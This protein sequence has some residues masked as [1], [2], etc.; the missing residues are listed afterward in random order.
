MRLLYTGESLAEWQVE[1]LACVNVVP[2]QHFEH[3]KNYP[4]HLRHRLTTGLT[5]QKGNFYAGFTN[6]PF[7]VLK[8]FA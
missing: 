6:S 1:D 7:N 3:D 4:N 5:R 2:V 8:I